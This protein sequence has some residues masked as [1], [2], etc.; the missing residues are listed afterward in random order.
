MGRGRGWGGAGG[1]WDSAGG[2]AGVEIL[3]WWS[4]GGLRRRRGQ[5]GVSV[6]P[7]LRTGRAPTGGF[8]VPQTGTVP[9]HPIP[10]PL[11]TLMGP[12][13]PPYGLAF[14]VDTSVGFI[15]SWPQAAEIHHGSTLT[16]VV[17]PPPH[18]E[19]PETNPCDSSSI[20]QGC[21]ANGENP[22]PPPLPQP[23]PPVR[24]HQPMGCGDPQ[25]SGPAVMLQ[26]CPR[27][28]RIPSAT[29]RHQRWSGDGQA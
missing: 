8:G 6:T 9:P 14:P 15:S 7:L 24:W 20:S 29:R 27:P 12:S 10:P 5:S 2:G 26:L 19:A 21:L 17:S 25:P 4:A 22:G 23:S 16:P 18:P 11:G 1:R 13:R 3:S 28:E